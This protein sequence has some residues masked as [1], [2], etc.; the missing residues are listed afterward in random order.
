MANL[1]HRDH[2]VTDTAPQHTNTITRIIRNY[3]YIVE[4]I[5]SY[6][7]DYKANLCGIFNK[8]LSNS[9]FK[10]FILNISRLCNLSPAFVATLQV[11]FKETFCI[12]NLLSILDRTSSVSLQIATI[13]FKAICCISH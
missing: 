6:S 8:K 12:L 10:F 4:Y 3:C 9:L 2:G 13:I 11:F 5:F 1:L 7:K